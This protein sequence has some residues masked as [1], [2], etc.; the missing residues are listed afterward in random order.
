MGWGS[1]RATAY[2]AAR[3]LPFA[4][5]V[6]AVGLIEANTENIARQ[7]PLGRGGAGPHRRG[8]GGRGGRCLVQPSM[9]GISAP[10]SHSTRGRLGRARG[11]RSRRR[12]PI[13]ERLRFAERVQNF[14]P[15]APRS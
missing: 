11:A 4:E 6:A 3:D 12:S 5:A 7:P 13:R 10:G 2:R 15:S 1:A 8:P 14:W 9:T